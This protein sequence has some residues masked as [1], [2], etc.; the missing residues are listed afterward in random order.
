LEDL[1]KGSLLLRSS[2]LDDN[3]TDLES[4]FPEDETEAILYQ[5]APNPF[6]VNTEIR[7]FLPQAVQQAYICIFDMQ[8]KMLKKLNV[9]AGDNILTIQGSE[10]QAGMYLYSLIADGKEMDTKRMIL[11]K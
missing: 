11:T 8:G 3:A 1:Q 5:N 6:Q 9:S 2:T 7:Y 10:L 4:I